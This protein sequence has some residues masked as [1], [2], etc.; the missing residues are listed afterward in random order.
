MITLKWV[1][2]IVSSFSIIFIS[3]K[4]LMDRKSHGF[5]RFFAWEFI[6]ILFLLNVEFWFLKPFAP[7]QIVS[8]IFL[9]SSTY[10]VIEG[11]RLLRTMGKTTEQRPEKHLYKLEKTS[12]LVTA[13][14]YK[15]IRHP[16]YGSL[17]FLAW[18]IFFKSVSVTGLILVMGT[19]L[20]LLRT[21]KIEEK[22]NV[23]YFG[24]EYT[25][26]RKRTKLFIPKIW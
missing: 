21:A 3:R 16:M 5:Y 17:L 14:I 13:G 15:Y 25:A 10:Y 11:F 26:Y 7:N 8:W 12:R 1:I 4:S 9:F 2:F 6:L 18:G 20:L 24:D 22:E 23:N 19:S